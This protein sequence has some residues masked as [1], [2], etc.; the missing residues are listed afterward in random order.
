[1]KLVRNHARRQLDFWRWRLTGTLRTHYTTFQNVRHSN[2]G[3]IAIGTA[4]LGLLQ[5]DLGWEAESVVQIAW[6]DLNESLIEEINTAGTPFVIGGSGYLHCGAEGNLSPL[7]QRDVPLLSKL[8][9]PVVLF[10]SGM[11]RILVGEVLSGP[12]CA[13]DM[14]KEILARLVDTLDVV[15]VRDEPTRAL[16]ESIGAQNVLVTGDPALHLP[17]IPRGAVDVTDSKRKLRIGIN[18][19]LHGPSS[20]DYLF[21]N[22][23]GYIDFLR[24]LVDEID[25]ELVYFCHSDGERFIH[26]LLKSSGIDCE[27]V[28]GMAADLLPVYAGLDLHVC[29]MMHSAIFAMSVGTP[30]INLGYDIKSFGLY[31]LM[32]HPDLCLKINEF[33]SKGLLIM[34]ERALSDHC[35]IR[36][37]LDLRKVELRARIAKL[38]ARLEEVASMTPSKINL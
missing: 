4:I 26:R 31:D 14:S 18:F 24:A 2:I 37:S 16:L 5:A 29:Q 32:G 1:M 25:C 3:D 11:N 13:T 7:V 27:F 30:T 8:T 10:A 28:S 21:A 33:D 34:V 20:Q 38:C 17:S 35:G 36:R 12:D 22:I 15:A 19:S 23:N 6:G 9:V